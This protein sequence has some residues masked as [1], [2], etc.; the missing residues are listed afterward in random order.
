MRR[1][2][3]EEKPPISYRV[4]FTCNVCGEEQDNLLIKRHRRVSHHC[5]TCDA[6]YHMGKD[7]VPI[8]DDNTPGARMGWLITGIPL[9]KWDAFEWEHYNR[10]AKEES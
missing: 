6:Y 9:S 4:E 3:E 5:P 10:L 1:K 2:V 8:C 7:G